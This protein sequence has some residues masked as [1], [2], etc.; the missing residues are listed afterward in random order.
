[1]T[2]A[3][4][5]YLQSWRHALE[6]DKRFSADPVK[7]YLDRHWESVLPLA[8]S[9]RRVF[10]DDQP[11][12][13]AMSR[14]RRQ[15]AQRVRRKLGFAD[16]T[17]LVTSHVWCALAEAARSTYFVCA[18]PN[19]R[20]GMSLGPKRPGKGQLQVVQLWHQIFLELYHS[21]LGRD[22][23]LNNRLRRVLESVSG[24]HGPDGKQWVQ[25]VLQTVSDTTGM[26][27]LSVTMAD[28]GHELHLSLTHTLAGSLLPAEVWDEIAKSV[29]A[30]AKEASNEPALS[31]TTCA[32]R[33]V[34]TTRCPE[35]QGDRSH[36]NRKGDSM[37]L[38]NALSACRLDALRA[39]M[40][41]CWNPDEKR[42]ESE[43][44]C[45]SRGNAQ[46][47]QEVPQNQ[48]PSIGPQALWVLYNVLW[49]GQEPSSGGSHHPFDDVLRL[50]QGLVC[51]ARIIRKDLDGT[52]DARPSIASLVCRTRKEEKPGLFLV[53]GATVLGCYDA[54][55][56]EDTL[57]VWRDHGCPQIPQ[58]SR[59]G[60][61]EV[62]RGATLAKTDWAPVLKKL[63]KEFSNGFASERRFA[64]A[65]DGASQS[66]LGLAGST[67]ES[68][69]IW[70]NWLIGP[71]G[72][73][74][75]VE[76]LSEELEGKNRKKQKLNYGE[77]TIYLANYSIFQDPHIFAFIDSQEYKNG[78]YCL[79][80][81]V[82]VR[83][84]NDGPRYDPEL[85]AREFTREAHR[86][87]QYPVATLVA[88]P[89]GRVHVYAAGNLKMSGLKNNG[90]KEE[91]A[92]VR[93]ELVGFIEDAFQDTAEKT[94]ADNI[95]VLADVLIEIRNIKGQGL[96]IA[97]GP[98][99]LRLQKAKL[100]AEGVD[101]LEALRST[102]LRLIDHDLI[103]NFAKLDG[104]I[105][106]DTNAS[107]VHPR[108]ALTTAMTKQMLENLQA[109]NKSIWNRVRH[110]LAAKGIRHR[111]AIC[112]VTSLLQL[113][114]DNERKRGK[115]QLHEL[116][117]RARA[118]IVS[119]DNELTKLWFEDDKLK[120]D[121]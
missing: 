71:P 115:P 58:Q 51:Y 11:R 69:D 9:L 40:N 68:K 17:E 97:F 8:R 96:S 73:L 21:V 27:A 83:P 47:H 7:V 114:K 33:I 109:E 108:V 85:P 80:H 39:L 94:H 75:E 1:M 119:S 88:R 29:A 100:L 61:A 15:K 12:Q 72:V 48:E 3:Y 93:R 35:P 18:S 13:R 59:G 82:R 60:Q 50:L 98:D 46:E 37:S 74:E 52:D 87:A 34:A 91:K 105:F 104:C 78:K 36:A 41:D 110:T 56:M 117:D 28:R 57:N 95:G 22:V 112:Y 113:I 53:R 26:P 89:D 31:P 43:S 49:R 2:T 116:R 14:E 92:N 30:A 76:V 90:Y 63:R 6:K 121:T 24:D 20:N 19:V 81:I 118:V 70:F 32:A 106:V 44:R 45:R 4:E 25:V 54:N 42:K 86:K 67:H 66:A 102:P 111:S 38:P 65:L 62:P 55:G 99:I 23:T 5:R 101:A 64:M 103:L 120:M 10:A 84:S 77:T 79:S 107:V 16:G